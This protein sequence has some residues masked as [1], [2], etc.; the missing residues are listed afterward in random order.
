[1]REKRDVTETRTLKT[2]A[3]SLSLVFVIVMILLPRVA[4]ATEVT[5]AMLVE[6]EQDASKPFSAEAGNATWTIDAKGRSCTTCHTDSVFVQ[7]RHERT[8]KVIEP[9]A[10]SVNADL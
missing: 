5:E 7:G 10:P 4:C 8:G 2:G 1:M 3:I 9:M 6:F